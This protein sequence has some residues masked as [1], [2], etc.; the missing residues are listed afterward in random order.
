MSSNIPLQEN[1]INISNTINTININHTIIYSPNDKNKYYR[2][3]LPNGLQYVV[4]SNPSI[5]RSAVGLDVLIGAADDPRDYQGLAHCLEH[6]IFLGSKKYPDASGFDNYLNNNSGTNNAN[7]SLESTNYHYDISH[8]VLEESISMFSELFKTPL[9]TKE[10]INKELNAIESEFKLDYRVD[11]QRLTQLI[12][13]EGY[14]NSTIN[15]FINGNLET[16]KKDD[17]REKVME[18]YNSKYDAKIMALSIFSNKTL[19]ELK[20]LVIKYF[21]DIKSVEGYQLSKKNILYDNNNMGYFYKII[22]IKDFSSICFNWIIN[23]TYKKYIKS[24]PVNYITSLLG[25]ET[26]HSL[27]SYLKKIGYIYSLVSSHESNLDL[28]TCFELKIKLTE[29]GY[30]NYEKVISI[31]LSYIDFIQKEEINKDFFEEIKNLSEIDFFLDSQNDPIDF[32][33]NLSKSL[34]ECKKEEPLYI[35][36]KIEEYRPDIIKE[37]LNSLTTHNLNIYLLS[38]KLK[39]EKEYVEN[40]STFNTCKI[41]GTEYLKTKKDFSEYVKDIKS[42]PDSDLGYPELNPFIAKDLNMIDLKKENINIDE[43]KYPKKMCDNE[44]IIWYKPVVKYNMPRVLF[45]GKA[46]ISNMNLSYESYYIYF[47]IFDRLIQKEMSDFNYFGEVSENDLSFSCNVSSIII[48]AVGYSDGLEKYITESFNILE[49]LI[50]NIEKI[51]NV[52]NK[53]QKILDD[54]IN[55]ANNVFKSGVQIQSK[56]MEEYILKKLKLKNKMKVYENFRNKL[57]EN[58]IPDEF[59]FFIRNFLK[60]VKFEWLVEGNI[61]YT[62]AERII[63]KMELSLNN[64]FGGINSDKNN[65]IVK[66]KEPLSIN[67]IRKQKITKLS[68]DKIYRYNFKSKDPKNESSVMMVYFQTEYLP[69][70]DNNIFNEEM[71]EKYIKYNIINDMMFYLFNEAFYDELRTE[72]QLGY[73]VSFTIDCYNVIFG[74]KF[75]VSSSKYSPDEILKHIN[76]F[77]IEHDLNKEEKFTD[78]NFEQYKKAILVDYMEKPLTLTKETSVDLSKVLDRYYIFDEK[79]RLIKYTKEKLNK[80]DVIEYFNNFIFK[81]AKRLE[82][83]LYSSVKKEEKNDNKEIKEEKME[84]EENTDKE[85]DKEN[86]EEKT[87][88]EMNENKSNK[89]D[90]GDENDIL[91]SYHNIE[92]VIINDIDDFHRS[93]T[94]Y[95]TEIY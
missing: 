18:F 24:D 60:K 2:D 35:T 37:I 69:F 95:D 84:I 48:K 19:D 10:L 20:N 44:H 51:E 55:R 85:K 92:K 42:F 27:T 57:N 87:D 17:I 28:F 59:L 6:T 58:K 21:S 43:F 78:E 16:L 15:T 90:D 40:K 73:D 3:I 74:V 68:E 38:H 71:Y 14:P 39:T 88:T 34:N 56:V 62:N 93:C 54:L 79:E 46:Y 67:E 45:I 26:R 72:Q 80:K 8:E 63:N 91:P 12:L 89:D 31:V 81:K 53:L 5:D 29:E 75:Y 9:F 86:K 76:K 47:D 36:S 1:P 52:I 70:N 25:H 4:I 22:P 13:S 30:N 83:A 61:I 94:Y 66:Y 49:K 64:L 41:Y 65:N 32:C 50:F 7:T 23:K 82:I 77:I 11:T 33:E